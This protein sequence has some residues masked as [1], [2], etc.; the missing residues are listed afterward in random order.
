M[1]VDEAMSESWHNMMGTV[2][3]A[4]P[5]KEIVGKCFYVFYF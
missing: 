2:L 5:N 1:K 3:S 4:Y